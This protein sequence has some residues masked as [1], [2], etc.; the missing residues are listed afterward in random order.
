LI[1]VN[2]RYRFGDRLISMKDDCDKTIRSRPWC[3]VRFQNVQ[4]RSWLLHSRVHHARDSVLCHYWILLKV[5]RDFNQTSWDTQPRIGWPFNTS[6]YVL[7]LCYCFLLVR[8]LLVWMMRWI[9]LFQR[10]IVGW[11][12]SYTQQL[13]SGDAIQ[14]WN[15]PGEC[16]I[17]VGTQL[18]STNE[19]VIHSVPFLIPSIRKHFDVR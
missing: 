9:L 1:P 7:P 12:A 16:S 14:K 4:Q 19:F 6:H 15:I 3:Q 8:L 2:N 10:W 17:V 5:C 11:Y 18:F 13:F